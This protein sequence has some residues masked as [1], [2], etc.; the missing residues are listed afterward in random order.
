MTRAISLVIVCLA[1]LAAALPVA[2][3][4]GT[5]SP[6][7]A[8][9]GEEP[10]RPADLERVPEAPWVAPRLE[11]A[12]A[13]DEPEKAVPV[14]VPSRPFSSRTAERP[15]RGRLCDLDARAVRLE[16]HRFNE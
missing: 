11:P 13:D 4:G 5:L 6:G 1:W 14:F 10:G 2:A 16:T 15:S 9:S 8:T 7:V 3:D 12:C